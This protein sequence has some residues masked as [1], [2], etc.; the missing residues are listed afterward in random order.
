MQA[1]KHYESWPSKDQER[2]GLIV[3]VCCYYFFGTLPLQSA[4]SPS[5]QA[6]KL[7][8]RVLRASEDPRHTGQS[9]ASHRS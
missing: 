2:F 7:P 8:R 1:F 6:A 9:A 3:V 5:S 4:G